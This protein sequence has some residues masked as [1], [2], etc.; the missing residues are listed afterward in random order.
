MALIRQIT[1]A[2][3]VH[4]PRAEWP[5]LAGAIVA[6]GVLAPVLLMFGL[7]GMPA[8]GAS[9]L[10]NAEGVF[11]ALLACT[12]CAWGL[13]NNRKILSSTAPCKKFNLEIRLSVIAERA[14]RTQLNHF[15]VD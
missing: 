11:T 10:L 13:D 12:S 14:L 9:L 15:P 6:G 7:R 4:L 1:G 5:W 8:T 2:A 3:P